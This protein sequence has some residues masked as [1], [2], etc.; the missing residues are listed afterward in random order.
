MSSID[1][2]QK[3]AYTGAILGVY[4]GGTTVPGTY[5]PHPVAVS[6]KNSVTGDTVTDLSAIV[7]GGINGLNN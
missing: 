6:Y 1:V 2:N 7:I 3:Y 4:S 5:A